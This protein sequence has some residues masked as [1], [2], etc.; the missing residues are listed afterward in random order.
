MWNFQVK[1]KIKDIK[2]VKN[3]IFEPHIG[4]IRLLHSNKN[5]NLNCILFKVYFTLK[6]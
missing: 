6:K 2:N 3:E 5:P 4:L 1:I